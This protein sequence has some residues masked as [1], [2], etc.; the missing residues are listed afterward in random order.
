MIKAF[1]AALL[2]TVFLFSSL[3]VV[4]QVP[5][6]VLFVGNSYTYFWNLPQQVAAMAESRKVAIN[7]SQSTSGGT[8]LAQHWRGDKKLQSLS[9][10]RAGAYDAVVLQDFSMQALNAPD[11]LLQYGQQFAKEAQAKGARVYLY[12]TWSRAFDPYMQAT[13]TA[14]YEELAALCDATIVPVGPAWERARS[15]RPDLPLYDP[16]Q[17]HP[18]PMGTY[19]AACVFYGVFTGQSPVGLPHRL[20]STDFAGE[21]LYLNI[22]ASED[23]L[24]CQKVAADVLGLPLISPAK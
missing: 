9:M 23:A 17:S 19:L 21:K 24:F 3:S 8:S 1:Y 11:T 6:K 13:I 5:E 15:L 2:A 7:T 16:D 4:A 22:Q 10:I 14:K 20:V 12:M 18:S